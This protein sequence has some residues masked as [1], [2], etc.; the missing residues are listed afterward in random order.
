MHAEQHTHHPGDNDCFGNTMSTYTYR[1]SI[2]NLYVCT[3][4]IHTSI[5]T[6]NLCSGIET[7]DEILLISDHDC[8]MQLRTVQYDQ[9]NK[10]TNKLAV[11]VLY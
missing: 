2:I 7:T 4:S 8:D 3:H 10:Q 11:A 9:P 1:T 6:N 5:D